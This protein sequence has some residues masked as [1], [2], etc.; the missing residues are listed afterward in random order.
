METAK[1]WIG[2]EWRAADAASTFEAENPSTGKKLG[3]T[4]P[5]SR[6]SDCDRALS[7]AAEAA[8]AMELVP[9]EKI[10]AFL[11][12]YAD[13]IAASAEKLAQAAHE[14][15]GLALTPRLKDV[16]I[17]RT[18]DQLRQ[19]AA[20]AR[21]GS[22]RRVTIDR[23]KNLRSCLGPV[24]PVAIFGPNNF[25]FAYNAASGGDF[26]SAIAAGN[27]VIA[28]AHPLHPFTS[29]LLAEECER[30]LAGSGLP[31]AAVQMV[32]HIEN[33]TGLR[34]VSDPRIG[35]F[36]FTGS[37]V[38]GLALKAAADKAGKPAYLEM[39][40]L[41]PVVF[42]PEGMKENAQ[43]WAAQLTDSCTAGSGQFCTRP[44]LV[45]VFASDATETFLK[46]VAAG[47]ESR[48]PH[49]LLSGSTRERLDDSIGKLRKAGAAVVTGGKN[50]D[51]E[52]Y[53]YAN[54]LLR[55]PG[56]KF[57][58]APEEFQREAFG[59][60][61]LA[62]VV[63][64]ADQLEQALQPMEGNLTAS[65]Y[66]AESGADEDVYG[67]V[68][69]GLRRR[70]GRFL[71][72]KMPTGVAVSPAMNHG[73]PYPSTGHPGFTAVGMPAS[74]TRFTVLQCYDN[75]REERLPAFL[76]GE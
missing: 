51:G 76:R 23:P 41:N 2:G 64:G 54:T 59:N 13:R 31:A 53:R 19:A 55:V 73:G 46:E 40:S 5:V 15:T 52:G 20:A 4:F 34:L 33:E 63:D 16:E 29:Q 27:P 72:D 65:V 35:A 17:P 11:E 12:A 74:I 39:S 3:R 18:V 25:P 26:A 8:H 36:A 38:A 6:W 50:L 28:K 69:P 60:E 49:A 7:A 1:V 71:N 44:N 24:G 10:A 58:E 30:A 66:S 21:Q 47:F 48:T 56:K 37:R 62:V 57:L 67:R 68:A 22:W 42:L 9:A 45:F 75:V 14:E 43:K 70:S 32:F 61:V